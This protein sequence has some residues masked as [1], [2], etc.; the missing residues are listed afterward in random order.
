MKT[1][2]QERCQG[3][4]DLVGFESVRWLFEVVEEGLGPWKLW[5]SA[6]AMDAV[7]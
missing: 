4:T 2:A 1:K 3:E 5:L 6:V 7:R